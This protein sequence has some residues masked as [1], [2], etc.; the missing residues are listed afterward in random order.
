[1]SASAPNARLRGILTACL[2]KKS[3]SIRAGSG[4]MLLL[5]GAW[6]ICCAA[7]V[8]QKATSRATRRNEPLSPSSRLRHR[9]RRIAKC[10]TP[11]L[12]R[13]ER[14]RC[15]PSYSRW[16]NCPAAAMGDVSMLAA[17]IAAMIFDGTGALPPLR[18]CRLASFAASRD[19][20]G[21]QMDVVLAGKAGANRGENR[22]AEQ[23]HRGVV[24]SGRRRAERWRLRYRQP[25]RGCSQLS[26]FAK[27]RH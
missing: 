10:S 21:R 14:E 19:R 18:R 1:M 2:L 6:P 8:C 27:R 26:P 24:C 25:A 22:D 5:I 17:S 7:R 15:T 11:G 16:R 23:L 9:N 12:R 20:K 3:P 13:P 4:A